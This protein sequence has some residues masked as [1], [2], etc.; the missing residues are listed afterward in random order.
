VFSLSLQGGFFIAEQCLNT[1]V[2]AI[3]ISAT[4]RVSVRGL[5]VPPLLTGL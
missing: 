2:G 3:K 1:T 5:L 4:T